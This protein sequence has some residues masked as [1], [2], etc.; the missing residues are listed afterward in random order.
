MKTFEPQ[1][2]TMQIHSQYPLTSIPPKVMSLPAIYNLQMR[3]DIKEPACD[4]NIKIAQRKK[5]KWKKE[6]EGG[7]RKKEGV[8]WIK[9]IGQD[10]CIHGTQ[11]FLFIFYVD[12]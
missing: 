11:C 2:E 1:L 12:T 6:G 10:M 3:G 8:E 4:W 7:R 9:R 5:K